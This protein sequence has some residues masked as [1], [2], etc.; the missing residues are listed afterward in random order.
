MLFNADKCKVMH[1]G[2]NNNNN[3]NKHANHDVNDV[4]LECVLEEKDLDVIISED[5]K[6]QKQCSEAVRK[7]NRMLGMIKRNFVDRSQETII[8]LYKSLVRPHLE[9]CCQLWRPYYKKDI[10]LIE[11]VQR[12]ATKLVTGMQELNYNDGLKRLGLQRLEGRRMRSDLIE[13]F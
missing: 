10:K 13:T 9:Y 1:V 7:A 3:N 12:R 11:G 4:Q 5:L 6:W 8:F 2:Y